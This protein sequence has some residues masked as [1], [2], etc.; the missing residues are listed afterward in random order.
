MRQGHLLNG[1]GRGS[2]VVVGLVRRVFGTPAALLSCAVILTIASPKTLRGQQALPQPQVQQVVLHPLQD[3]SLRWGDSAGTSAR[4][5]V[6]RPASLNQAEAD[7]ALGK[8]LE[9]DRQDACVDRYYRAAAGAWDILERPSRPAALLR[10]VPTLDR[11]RP[12]IAPFFGREMTGAFQ[13]SPPQAISRD[14]QAAWQIYQQSLA[15]LIPAATRFR[16]LDPRGRLT[17]RGMSG[18]LAV[19]IRYYG[20]AWQPSAFCRLIPASEHQGGDLQRHYRTPGLGVALIAVRFSCCEEPFSPTSVPFAVTAVLRA[21]RPGGPASASLTAGSQA[22]GREAVLEFYNPYLFESLPLGARVVRLE[23]DLSAPLVYIQREA[24]QNYLQAFLDPGETD[25]RPK[26][27]MM[28]PYQRGKIPVVFIHGLLSDPTTWLD[29]VNELRA[30]SDLDRRYQFWYYRY[31]TG[32][33][34]LESAAKLREQ[35]LLAREVCDPGA[36]DASMGRMVLIGHSMGGLVARLQVTYAYDILWQHV[37]RRPLETVVATPVMRK[38]LQRD[39]Y[40]D[41]S[42]LVSRVVFIGTP[43]RGAGMARRLGGRVASSLVSPFGSE[44][45]LYR[46]LIDQ[47]PGVFYEYLQKS[48]PTSIDL[49]E[50]TNP[51]LQ[52]LSRMPYGCGVWLH[53]IVGDGGSILGGEAGDGIVPLSSARHPGV[54]SELVVP[55]RHTSL[56]RDPATVAELRRILRQHAQENRN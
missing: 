25:V 54:S 19:P 21:S 29:A 31:P 45:P 35:L 14:Y 17:V 38:R 18:P 48:P 2:W 9:E 11:G 36:Q 12:T 40:F 8:R 32:G 39:L 41:P 50:P 37:A 53:S 28:E 10:P 20:F 4:P 5:A 30:N 23:R 47:N 27:F 3:S 34:V 44:E 26:L 7:L 33:G 6:P 1:N 55:A 16:R 22:E 43:H 51:L 13:D 46:Q 49:L 56:H 52:A 42:P 24:P 15:R